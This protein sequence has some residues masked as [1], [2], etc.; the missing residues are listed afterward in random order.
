MPLSP[1]S[2]GLLLHLQHNNIGLF[3]AMS[4]ISETRIVL[5]VAR[6]SARVEVIETST[7]A[8]TLVVC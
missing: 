1:L 6:L 7:G 4:C 2:I 8:D 5:R 3:E